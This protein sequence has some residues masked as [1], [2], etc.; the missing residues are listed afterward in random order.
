MWWTKN[1]SARLPDSELLIDRTVVEALV[2]EIVGRLIN[3]GIDAGR[4]SALWLA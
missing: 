4:K 2:L 3:V 1:S